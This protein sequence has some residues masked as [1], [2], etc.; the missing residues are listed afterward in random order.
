MTKKQIIFYEFIQTIV[1]V[2]VVGNIGFFKYG[3]NVNIWFTTKV[4]DFLK[5]S[6]RLQ[7]F[8]YYTYY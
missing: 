2:I 4:G 6:Y 5:N 8:T 1:Y 7:C 3:I